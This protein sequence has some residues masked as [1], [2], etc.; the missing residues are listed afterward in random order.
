MLNLTYMGVFMPNKISQE[1]KDF[2]QLLI[3]L[4]DDERETVDSEYIDKVEKLL[5]Q[6]IDIFVKPKLKGKVDLCPIIY[7]KEKTRLEQDYLGQ[8]FPE[9][10]EV[11]VYSERLLEMQSREARNL[12]LLRMFSTVAHEIRHYLQWLYNATFENFASP[13]NIGDYEVVEKFDF[14]EKLLGKNAFEL[15]DT[16]SDMGRVNKY[17]NTNI[18]RK[19]LMF[20]GLLDLVDMLSFPMELNNGK[21]QYWL[22]WIEQDARKIGRKT[23]VELMSELNG[24]I[25]SLHPT[26]NFPKNFE[27]VKNIKIDNMMAYGKTSVSKIERQKKGEYERLSNAPQKTERKRIKKKMEEHYAI[28]DEIKRNESST[29]ET[30]EKATEIFEMICKVALQEI[31][32]E[33]YFAS[34]ENHVKKLTTKMRKVDV[35]HFVDYVAKK[36]SDTEDENIKEFSQLLGLCIEYNPEIFRN[37]SSL[38]QI[39]ENYDEFSM[40]RVIIEGKIEQLFPA[41]FGDDFIKE[42]GERKVGIDEFVSFVEDLDKQTEVVGRGRIFDNALGKLMIFSAEE[43]DNFEN[44]RKLE[45]LF[46]GKRIY[47]AAFAVKM[48]INRLYAESEDDQSEI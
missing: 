38:Q 28:L 11:E 4:Y 6:F 31:K 13:D 21:T 44:L 41:R 36:L 48:L 47:W 16:F 27:A 24:Y 10:C 3:E 5:N 39:A 23:Q 32:K 9:T 1:K 17:G 37:K 2:F 30:V 15:G 25:K 42:I 26:V 40:F 7:T 14:L 34:L 46:E 35:D 8:F 22:R 43:F 18:M 20:C 12:M 19:F 29:D 45:E 33:D